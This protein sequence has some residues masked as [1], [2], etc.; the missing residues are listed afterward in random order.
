[1]QVSGRTLNFSHP[2]QIGTPPER[3][4][5]LASPFGQSE[6]KEQG[7]LAALAAVAE[8]MRGAEKKDSQQPTASDAYQTG[9]LAKQARQEQAKG[10][11]QIGSDAQ[12]DKD[13]SV[14]RTLEK[15][16]G[17]TGIKQF[18][19]SFSYDYSH[20]E[21][22]S[23]REQLAY[24][25][26]SSGHQGI[27]YDYQES[28]RSE[29]KTKMSMNGI[30]TMDDG[31]SF[32]FTIDYSMERLAARETHVQYRSPGEQSPFPKMNGLG[33][34]KFTSPVEKHGSNR[35][36]NVLPSEIGNGDYAG[37][38]DHDDNGNGY[39]DRRDSIWN[40]LS[41]GMSDEDG[42]QA[43]VNWRTAIINLIRLELP[44]ISKDE[45]TPPA[46]P[47]PSDKALAQNLQLSMPTEVEQPV[48]LLT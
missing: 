34:L 43:L 12:G 11:Q 16:F 9:R 47:G 40:L 38:A 33:D 28:Y 15:I 10:Q 35:A 5:R 42:P 6:S 7:P 39:I 31:R 30:M 48:E 2:N 17:V 36:Y 22:Q 27:N 41:L 32:A 8:R 13:Q 4:D 19:A 29:T 37:I 24:T 21:T 44:Y 26:S 46:E 3:N 45:D 23:S 14:A 20:S 1:M 25:Q 18:S